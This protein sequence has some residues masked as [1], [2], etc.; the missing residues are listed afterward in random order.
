[1]KDPE[2][3]NWENSYSIDKGEALGERASVEV[4]R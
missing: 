4:S 3:K 2:L 1:M